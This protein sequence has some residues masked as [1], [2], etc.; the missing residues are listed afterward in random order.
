M[1]RIVVRIVLAF[2]IGNLAALGS[3]LSQSA[4]TVRKGMSVDDLTKL[5]QSIPALPGHIYS[6]QFLRDAHG[7][8]PGFVSLLVMNPKGGWYVYVFRSEGP[9]GFALD[10]KSGICPA[11]LG[12]SAVG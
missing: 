5:A 1:R 7:N 8:F 12:F 3:S 6:V 11:H 10:W 4:P 9:D 2:L